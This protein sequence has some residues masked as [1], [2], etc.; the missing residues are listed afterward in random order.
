MPLDGLWVERIHHGRLGLPPDGRDVLGH[1][2]ERL[3]GAPCEEDPRP[4]A[5][6]CTGDAATYRPARPV[7]DGVLIL[8]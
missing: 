8:Q 6:E 5:G 2:L 3:A 4:L 7:D 1:S